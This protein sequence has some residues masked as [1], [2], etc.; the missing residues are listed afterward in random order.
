M[1]NEKDTQANEPLNTQN[2]AQIE[3]QSEPQIE[4]ET[5]SN[6]EEAQ[7]LER[8]VNRSKQKKIR[9]LIILGA[10][11]SVI[12]VNLLCVAFKSGEVTITVPEGTSSMKIAEILKEEDVIESKY[13]FLARLKFSEFN[14]KLRY[15][16]FTFDKSDSY[17]KIIKKLAT[18]GAK[19]NTVTL[20]IPEGYSV[21][22][23]KAKVVEL[24]FCTDNEFEEALKKDYDFPFLKSAPKNAKVKYRL[25]GYLYPST[26]EFYEDAKAEDIIKTMLDEFDKQTKDLGIKDWHKTI[27]LASL[28]ER[29]AKLDKERELIAGVMVNRLNEDMIL[30]IDATVV[31]AI[32]DGMYDVDRVF[33]KDLK[34]DSP[35]NTYKYNGLPAGAICSP[36]IKSI[37][38]AIN[39]ANHNFLYYHTDTKKNDGSHIFT[40]TYESHTSTMN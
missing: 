5:Q 6:T 1:E 20:T 39:P 28:V 27:T 18:S 22:R 40:E 12:L 16:T 17:I 37:K 33:Y 25:Q 26:Y 19:K 23:I 7:G 35:Y 31:Y 13:L 30:Q 10:I 14:G 36:S 9:K 4:A 24:G 2:E 32:S 3:Q 11:L 29:E 15:G 38:A 8:L 21:E 34:V